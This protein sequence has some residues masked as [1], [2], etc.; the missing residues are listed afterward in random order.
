M[1]LALRLG[2]R[3]RGRAGVRSKPVK[4]AIVADIHANVRALDAVRADLD[5]EAPD[6]VVVN[7]DMVNRGPN[8]LAVLE[9]LEQSGWERTLGNHD[10]LM[11]K[12]VDKDPDLPTAW[13]DDPFW[14]G[15]AWSAER[16]DAA[17]R[18]D[19]LRELP[20]EIRVDVDGAPSVLV[21]HGSPRHYRE[22]YGRYLSDHEFSEIAQ[23][24]PADVYVGSH[25]HQPMRRSW[26]RYR[27]YNTGAVGTP[28]NGDPRAQY[29]ILE[30]RD[31]AWVARFRR[32]PYDREAALDDFESSDYL[33]EGGLSARIFY[34]ETRF[35]RS[36]YTPFVMWTEREELPQDASTWATFRE[37]YAHRVGTPSPMPDRAEDVDV[38]AYIPPREDD[39]A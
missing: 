33:D 16:L 6:R 37:R 22:G 26:G 13:F 31:G 9:R 1:A 4:L 23:M 3:A 35:A 19:P 38:P 21:T 25:T 11:R 15:T 14:D 36:F 12:W 32:V 27:I 24:H 8:N 10:D 28:F 17:G 39:E 5:G 34:E 7:G 18:I 20:M 30:L 29:L 2:P